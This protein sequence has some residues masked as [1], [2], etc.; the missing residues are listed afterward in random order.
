MTKTITPHHVEFRVS[1]YM[2]RIEHNGAFVVYNS[3]GKQIE[4]FLKGEPIRSEIIS[5]HGC[6]EVVRKTKEHK[7]L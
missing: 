6:A 1:G 4:C 7:D 3:K 2:A 5:T